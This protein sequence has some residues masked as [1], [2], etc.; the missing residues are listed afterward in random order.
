MKRRCYDENE[1][2]FEH[3]GG[4]GIKMCDEWKNDFS[5]FQEWALSNGFDE[6]KKWSECTIDRIDVNGNYEPSNCRWV[7]MHTQLLNRRAARLL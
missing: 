2:K 1:D 4:R 3:Y 7:D 6:E 5:T